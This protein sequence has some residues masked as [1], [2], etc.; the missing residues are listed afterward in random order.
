MTSPSARAGKPFVIN[1]RR[2]EGEVLHAIPKKTLCRCCWREIRSGDY[3]S[4]DHAAK[5]Q[6]LSS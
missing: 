3:C 1:Q 2:I 6:R 4:D 5:H